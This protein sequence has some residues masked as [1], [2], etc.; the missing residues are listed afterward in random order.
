MASFAHGLQYQVSCGHPLGGVQKLFTKLLCVLCLAS[1]NCPFSASFDCQMAFLIIFPIHRLCF[2]SVAIFNH[3][4]LHF[5][6]VY[7]V[8]MCKIGVFN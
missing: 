2:S 1:T 8:S 7:T 6:V 4:R 3:L 5:N